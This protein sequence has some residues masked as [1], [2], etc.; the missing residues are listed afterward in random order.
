MIYW[1]LYAKW[2]GQNK[3]APVNWREGTQVVNKIH[4]SMFTS[5]EKDKVETELQS[6]LENNEGMAWDWRKA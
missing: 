3:F 4:A 2:P 6:Q 1:L 5:E